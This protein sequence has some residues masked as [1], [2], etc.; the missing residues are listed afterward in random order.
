M[1]ESLLGVFLS[2]STYKE[3]GYTLCM[4]WRFTV[5]SSITIE[6]SCGYEPSAIGYSFLSNVKGYPQI[7]IFNG[8]K[9]NGMPPAKKL[10][11]SHPSQFID[12]LILSS[13][14]P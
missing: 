14:L 7:L 12:D 13:K 6:V 5:E 10:M 3:L 4:T 11:A 1:G 2:G 8:R 9:K